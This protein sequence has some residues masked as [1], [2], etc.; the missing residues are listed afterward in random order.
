MNLRK[1]VQ[2]RFVEAT[3]S[4]E[5]E[6]RKIR[7]CLT[8]A[9]V[10]REKFKT[11]LRWSPHDLTWAAVP[12]STLPLGSSTR[13]SSRVIYTGTIYHSY[14]ETLTRRQNAGP[15]I[16]H[17]VSPGTHA[18]TAASR[19][20]RSLMRVS[21]TLVQQVVSTSPFIIH[22]LHS[23]ATFRHTARSCARIRPGKRD[24]R[25]F[26]KNSST[27]LQRGCFYKRETHSVAV[28]GNLTWTCITFEFF[29]SFK[30]WKVVGIG[31][32]SSWNY[33]L[34]NY[35]SDYVWNIHET[36]NKIEK[37]KINYRKIRLGTTRIVLWL[38]SIFPVI[39]RKSY[40]F[41]QTAPSSKRKRVSGDSQRHRVETS[42]KPT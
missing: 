38:L 5:R 40:R 3:G 26:Y 27:S 29:R 17:V 34:R 2:A 10:K 31:L 25:V 1:N 7:I 14:N 24:D 16:F 39:N 37:D 28:D 22:L 11:V 35:V 9:V 8:A 20:L 18:V 32:P 19:P 41:H 36:L 15:L 33:I 13:C 42:I 21:S 30:W 6:A 4:E 23:H 12:F